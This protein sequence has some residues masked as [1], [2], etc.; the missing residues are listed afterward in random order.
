ML[1]VSS[2][3][4]RHMEGFNNLACQR[5]STLRAFVTSPEITPS[6]DFEIKI[7]DAR[8]SSTRT[9]KKEA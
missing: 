9:E 2:H 4:V 8:T 6:N 1:D 5:L 7:Q 3:K